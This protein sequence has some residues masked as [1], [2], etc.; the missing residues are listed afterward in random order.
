M[1]IRFLQSLVAVVETGSIVAAA[2]RER[3]TPAAVSQRIQSLERSLGRLLLVRGAH[4]ARPTEGCLSMLPRARALIRDASLLVDDLDASGLS[5]DLRVGAISTVLTGLMPAV[6]GNIAERA[7]LLKLRLTPGTSEQLYEQM[8]A[9]RLD[10]AVLVEPPFALLKA[11]SSTSI[12]REPLVYLTRDSV[13]PEEIAGHAQSAPFIRYDPSSWGG[14][15]VADYMDGSGL[16]PEVRCDMDAL[17]TIA[18]LVAKGMGN[19]LVPHWAGLVADGFNIVP[20]ADAE[21]HTRRLCCL[22]PNV[23]PKPDAVR[24]LRELLVEAEDPGRRV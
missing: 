8:L 17:E 1:D 22:S 10:A 2:R 14:R 19:S 11:V 15:I 18:I 13:A 23:S 9:G 7:P 4:T 20:V 21:A 6:L 12:S 24:L 5:G 3:L 16:F